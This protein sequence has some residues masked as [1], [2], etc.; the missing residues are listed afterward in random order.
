MR[1]EEVYASLV[2]IAVIGLVTNTLMHRIIAW[3][4]PWQTEQPNHPNG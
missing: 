3:L 4:V 2:V 1:I